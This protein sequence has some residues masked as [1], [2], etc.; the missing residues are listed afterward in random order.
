MPKPAQMA[1]DQNIGMLS[2]G[3][4]AQALDRA[5]ASS[6]PWPGAEAAATATEN[7]KRSALMDQTAPVTQLPQ[8]VNDFASAP[9]GLSAG[10][11]NHNTSVA[12]GASS[13]LT[14]GG[15]SS[16]VLALLESIFGSGAN[17][18]GGFGPLASVQDY[19]WRLSRQP[20]FAPD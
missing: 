13:S 18:G 17:H 15:P 14:G 12:V 11:T 4:D 2:A 5:L 20:G 6:Q 1:S 7:G 9:V 19:A 16:S 3:A 8:H 10:G